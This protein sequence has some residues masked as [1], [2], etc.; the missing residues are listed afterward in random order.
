[1]LQV[2]FLKCALWLIDASDIWA[3]F[4]QKPL[5]LLGVALG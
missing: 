5:G 4:H 3:A 1:M 2:T